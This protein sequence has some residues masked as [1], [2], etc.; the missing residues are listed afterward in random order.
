MPT[1]IR[2][3]LVFLC[4]FSLSVATASAATITYT[5]Q[6]LFE[7]QLG[8]DFTLVNLDAPPLSAFSSGYRVEDPLPAAA[9]LG[10]GIDFFGF[11]AQVLA[12]QNGQTP[13]NR[14]RLLAHGAG[15]GGLIAVNFV[16]PVN[17]IGAFSNNIDFGR[18]RA[19]SALDLGGT[20]LGQ[21]QF[22]PGAF[23]GLTSDILIGSAQFTCDFN[24][25]LRCGV[26]DIQFGTFDADATAVPEPTSLL[27][28]TTGAAGLFAKAK[29][30]RK[31]RRD[32]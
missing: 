20:F 1:S 6:A 22:G 16:D 21:V 18:I 8:G 12:G 13:T 7:A 19:F 10:L 5:N 24:A 9:F 15:N 2:H 30:R 29:Q 3:A 28:V 27:L 26:Y 31:R 14:D 11:N 4:M 25:D 17:G 23:G 32:H